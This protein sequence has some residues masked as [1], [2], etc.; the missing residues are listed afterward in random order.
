MSKTSLPILFSML[1]YKMGQDLRHLRHTVSSNQLYI[2][3]VMYGDKFI[4]IKI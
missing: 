2:C 4:E 1:R 3:N